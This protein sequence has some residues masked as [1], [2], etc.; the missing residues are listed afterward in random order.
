MKPE[1]KI[2]KTIVAE[3]CSICGGE[4]YDFIEYLGKIYCFKCWIDTRAQ[5]N[6]NPTEEE[7]WGQKISKGE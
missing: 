6:P 1:G 4:F 2:Q 5:R 3:P 7:L